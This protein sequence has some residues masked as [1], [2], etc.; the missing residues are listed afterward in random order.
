M[1]GSSIPEGVDVCLDLLQICTTNKGEAQKF[2][3]VVP[4]IANRGRQ[5]I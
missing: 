3:S 1:W 2:S 5:I 4:L